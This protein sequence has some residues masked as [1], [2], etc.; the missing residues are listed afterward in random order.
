[1]GST[2]VIAEAA[3]RAGAE[4]S[5]FELE[6]QFRCAGSKGFVSWVDNTLGLDETAN[7]IWEGDEAFD[8]QIVDSVE[9]LDAMIRSKAD[10]GHTARLTAGFCWRWSDPEPD[11]TL[12]NDVKVGAWEMPWNA[13]SDAG[14][15]AEGIPEERFWASDPRGI[16]QVGCVYTAQ[17]FEFD[18]VGVI[19]GRDLRWD[20]HPGLDRRLR[21]LLR[22][23]RQTQR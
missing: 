12:V 19:F 7:P 11:G 18:Y 14:R 17:G 20:P 13:R 6:T 21:R 23:H 2:D 3:L 4:L 10:E 22:Q 5:V 16:N 9:Q 1:M 15:L 8:F